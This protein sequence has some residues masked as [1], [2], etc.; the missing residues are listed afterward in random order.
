MESALDF[1]NF[2]EEQQYYY[3]EYTD[4]FELFIKCLR[5]H[6]IKDDFFAFNDLY[7][8]YLKKRNLQ[9]NKEHFDI[10]KFLAYE[11]CDDLAGGSYSFNT[12]DTLKNYR[13]YSDVIKE[14]KRDFN[15]II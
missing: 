11:Y 12:Y 5:K 8:L 6:Q 3:S 9:Y 7:K 13:F 2:L 4:Q 1:I 15:I 14:M 10:C